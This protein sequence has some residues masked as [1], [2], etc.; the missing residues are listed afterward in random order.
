M[1][2]AS[3]PSAAA[4]EVKLSEA[5]IAQMDTDELWATYKRTNSEELKWALVMR[6][7]GLIKNVAMQVRGVYS[8]FAQVDDIVSEGILTLLSAVEKF[9]PTRGIKFETYISKRIRGMVID[10]ARKQDWLPR[11][12]RK[13]T[14]EID[15]AISLL[16][17]QLG[18]FPT[19]REIADLLGI[20]PS[21]YYKDIASVALSNILS[22]DALMDVGERDGHPFEMHAANAAEQPEAVLQDRELQETLAEGIKSLRENEQIVLSL[23]YEKN[24]HMKE[25]SQ[26]LDVSEPRVSQIHARAIQKLRLYMEDYFNGKPVRSKKRKREKHV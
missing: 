7:E 2:A 18:R 25:I 6:Y 13:R 4:E 22:L 23:Y 21:K 15:K 24:L 16:S 14:K 26:V 3:H 19:D 9:D 20:S 11:N 1:P 10:L 17:N 12:I 8:N 5:E